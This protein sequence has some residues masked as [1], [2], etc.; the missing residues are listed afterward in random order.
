MTFCCT[1]PALEAFY[2]PLKRL[3]L[4]RC[5]TR[6][7]RIAIAAGFLLTFAFPKFNVAGLAWIAPAFM[8][9]S[10][11]GFGGAAAF[12]IGFV[13]GFAH[14]LG[15]LHWLLYIPM[16]FP[17]K[18]MV[19]LGWLALGAYLAIF[20]GFWTWFGWKICP[21]KIESDQPFF[22][23]IKGLGKS[24]W[25]Q[26]AVWSLLLA[27]S[28]VATE[29]IQSRFLSGFPWGLL[30]VSQYRMTPLIQIS[31]ITGV[32]GVAFLLVWFSSALLCAVALQLSNPP[33]G[34]RWAAE[35]FAPVA[36]GAGVF[37][38]GFHQILNAPPPPRQ[39]KVALIQ[40]SIPQT[41]IWDER[42]AMTRFH[43]VLDW[44]D[45][46]LAE[47]P[48]PDLLVWPE[49]AVPNI[50]RWDTKL[51]DGKTMF[52]W[53]TGFAREH[54][55][56]LIMGADD[57]DP[58]PGVSTNYFNSS[59]LINPAGEV[60]ARYRKRRLVIFGE[61][62]PF[63]KWLPFLSAMVQSEGEFTPG[64]QPVSFHLSSPSP[65]S[66]EKAGVRG[67]E[68]NVTTS[69]LICFEDVFPHL[70]REYVDKETDFL[71]NLTNNGWFGESAAQW[72]HAANAVFR[73]VENNI[74]LVRCANNGLTCWVDRRG[75]MHDV[76][77]PGSKDIY[78]AGYKIVDVPVGTKGKY[79]PT[80]YRRYGD[81]FGWL[82]VGAT[83]VALLSRRISNSPKLRSGG[84]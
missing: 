27:A 9:A 52:D 24:S 1:L 46:S 7:Y 25:A 67:R 20:Q 36:I 8:L 51:Y 81:V 23:A 45:K 2:P 54:Q 61:Y 42:E 16:D 11:A 82:C 60:L 69:V 12:R 64:D 78:K 5:E 75:N 80:F 47:K 40:P 74:P 59:F 66:G 32:Y 14:H 84:D 13:A 62:V 31:S 15:A 41:M 58:Q 63:S 71:L 38:F 48:R 6:R 19:F 44:S 55:I 79:I 50:F 4:T 22:A 72:Q 83:A 56:W 33:G 35:L 37:A 53:I 65:P 49:A 57:A 17:W 73:A 3:K 70:A 21:A 43:Q 28:W 18:G 76:Y 10:A 34:R 30:G 68:L 29:M 77:F 39:L 26:R